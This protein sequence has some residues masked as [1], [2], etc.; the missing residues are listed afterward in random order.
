MNLNDEMGKLKD[1]INIFNKLLN[2]FLIQ[3]ET[4]KVSAEDSLENISE[5][6]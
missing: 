3:S 6:I 2:S 4:I 5:I 1:S